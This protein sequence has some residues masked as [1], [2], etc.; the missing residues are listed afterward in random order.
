MLL[1]LRAAN[2]LAQRKHVRMQYARL[3]MCDILRGTT[4][5]DMVTGNV[6][7][8]GIYIC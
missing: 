7:S 6:E 5:K 4:G 3:V 1:L 8:T 2:V